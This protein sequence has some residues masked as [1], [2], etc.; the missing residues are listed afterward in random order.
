MLKKAPRATLAPGPQP[1]CFEVRLL[2]EEGAGVLVRA[3]CGSLARVQGIHVG[4]C[5]NCGP[6]L[7]P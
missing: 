4:G 7:G 3:S 6:F 2:E 1:I 5:Q